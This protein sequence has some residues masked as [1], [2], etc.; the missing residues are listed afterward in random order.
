MGLAFCCTL[1]QNQ[2]TLWFDRPG[3]TSTLRL[4]QWRRGVYQE[5][6][7]LFPPINGVEI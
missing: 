1:I 4:F 6:K 7:L 5:E 2:P 3:W